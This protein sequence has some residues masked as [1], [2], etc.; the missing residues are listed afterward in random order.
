MVIQDVKYYINGAE[1]QLN[2]NQYNENINT[3]WKA[4]HKKLVDQTIDWFEKWK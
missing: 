2:K 4:T 1:S 3:N